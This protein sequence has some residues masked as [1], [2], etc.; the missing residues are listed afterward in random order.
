MNSL[1]LIFYGTPQL[2]VPYLDA[3]HSVGF[4]P[5][6]IITAPDKPVGRK[7]I[8]TPPPVKVW[9]LAH[10]IPC[11]QPEKLTP[12]FIESVKAM[13]PFD[14]SILIAFGKILKQPLIDLPEHGTLNVHYSLLPRHRGAS[15]TEATILSG[16]EEGGVTIQKMV[17]E[18]DAGDIISAAKI[19]LDGT[20]FKRDL[21]DIL[22][23][24]GCELL[25]DTI[26]E[27]LNN[28][29]TLLPQGSHGITHCTKIEKDDGLID[30]EKDNHLEIWRKFRAYDGWPGIFFVNTEGKRTNITQAS[31]ENDLFIIEKVVVEGETEK[32]Y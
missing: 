28:D 19:P 26:P 12:E 24:I 10:D 17:F 14:L 5:S 8:I 16:D 2:C 29:I 27:Y 6:L 20:E 15:P 31:F 13:G 30:I 18:L 23:E 22:S 9:A 3:L 21:W 25:I 7:Q 32:E 11:L 4:T 1:K